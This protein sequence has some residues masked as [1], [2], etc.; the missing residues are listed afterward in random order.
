MGWDLLPEILKCIV[1][2]AFLDRDFNVTDYGS[3]GDGI[4]DYYDPAF[5]KAIVL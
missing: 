5:Q 2:P 4:T 3:V 1:P